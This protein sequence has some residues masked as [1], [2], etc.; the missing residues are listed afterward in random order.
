MQLQRD[1]NMGPEIRFEEVWLLTNVASES[2][3][4][5]KEVVDEGIFQETFLFILHFCHNVKKIT[6][7][8]FFSK[9]R[10]FHFL[11]GGGAIIQRFRVFFFSSDLIF[12][13]TLIAILFF[14]F[15]GGRGH[16][17]FY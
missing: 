5:T 11:E 17:V 7:C 2:S 9:F 4:H 14:F 10:L 6:K 8:F 13:I 3:N 15:G 12:L 1:S 16:C